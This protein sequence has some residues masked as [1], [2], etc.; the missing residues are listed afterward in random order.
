MRPNH[1]GLLSD[2]A[3]AESSQIAQG[4]QRRRGIE[5][6]LSSLDEKVPAWYPPS[7]VL[8]RSRGAIWSGLLAYGMETCAS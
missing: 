4:L 8:H 5:S 3:A 1:Q 7:G 2:A 6:T